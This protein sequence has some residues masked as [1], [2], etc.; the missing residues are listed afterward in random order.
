MLMY[1]FWISHKLFS[2]TET[3]QNELQW[4][5]DSF[6]LLKNVFASCI[7][8]VWANIEKKSTRILVFF[9]QGSWEYSQ[10][11]IYQTEVPAIF[12]N[13]QTEQWKHYRY[14]YKMKKLTPVEIDRSTFWFNQKI[15]TRHIFIWIP[16]CIVFPSP[17]IPLLKSWASQRLQALW[18]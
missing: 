15:S 8:A 10:V 14:T 4:Y 12:R 3:Y 18:K 16:I 7:S 2:H 5:I 6:I 11:T 1:K 9:K 17:G 13:T